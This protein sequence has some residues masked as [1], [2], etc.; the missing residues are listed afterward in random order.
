MCL[1]QFLSGRRVSR[2]LLLALLGLKN[3]TREFFCKHNTWHCTLRNW[4]F[5]VRLF[6]KESEEYLP[7]CNTM[8]ELIT[9]LSLS[10]GPLFVSI[11]I[12]K[13]QCD[14]IGFLAPQPNRE[15][16]CSVLSL[17][18]KYICFS[19]S[20]INHSPIINIFSSI[21]THRCKIKQL[22]RFPIHNHWMTL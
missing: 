16:T 15:I 21:W 13:D 14:R 5:V 18:W 2:P 22:S 12:S 6:L 17:R 20:E 8:S 4:E 1:T 3:P 19:K 7:E 9:S 10:P 11:R